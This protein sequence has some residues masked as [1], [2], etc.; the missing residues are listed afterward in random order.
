MT[1]GA[2]KRLRRPLLL[3]LLAAAHVGGIAILLEPVARAATPALP[4]LIVTAI[5][6]PGIVAETPPPPIMTEIVARV[7]LP[8]IVAEDEVAAASNPCELAAN[9]EAAL[10]DNLDARV[11]VANIPRRARSVSN[12]LLLWDGDW[13]NAAVVGGYA[14]LGPIRAAVEAEVRAAPIACR[15][16]LVVGPRLVVVP[17]AGVSIVL[18]FGSGRWSWQKLLRPV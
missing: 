4:A 14:T 12:A 8:E 15:N 10:R 16:E 3:T 6:A 5:P 9:V 2:V 17:D 7:E 1:T 18:A 11:A 13:A